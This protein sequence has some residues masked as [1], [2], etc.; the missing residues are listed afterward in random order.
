LS[1]GRA[2][3][4]R[5]RELK[6]APPWQRGGADARAIWDWQRRR[7]TQVGIG[8]NRG[9]H[10]LMVRG[11]GRTAERLRGVSAPHPLQ[12]PP[13]VRF[14]LASHAFFACSAASRFAAA[15]APAFFS[16]SSAEMLGLVFGLGTVLP[17]PVWFDGVL[18]SCAAAGI[19][20]ARAVTRVTTRIGL[21]GDPK[22]IV[23]VVA[24]PIRCRE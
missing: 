20:S 23:E 2:E 12:I 19:A 1:Y 3:Q 18:T 6:K 14:N 15:A 8:S 13:I 16:A 9:A 24:K 7:S 22:S 10:R 17:V 4:G 21:S 5:P 11:T